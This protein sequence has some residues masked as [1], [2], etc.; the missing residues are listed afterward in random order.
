[1]L[2]RVRRQPKTA[3]T[4]AHNQPLA[5]EKG[6]HAVQAAHRRRVPSRSSREKS[7]GHGSPKLTGFDFILRPVS[8]TKQ[9]RKVASAFKKE[10]RVRLRHDEHMFVISILTKGWMYWRSSHNRS[11]DKA[12]TRKETN[13]LQE[14]FAVA[15]HRYITTT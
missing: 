1:M 12:R 4:P 7:L 13:A 8:V 6:T 9:S 15:A 3:G 11:N 2:G 14:R 10:P 5:H